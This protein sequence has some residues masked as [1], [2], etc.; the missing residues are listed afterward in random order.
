MTLEHNS[1]HENDENKKSSGYEEETKLGKIQN[2]LEDAFYSELGMKTFRFVMAWLA[3]GILGIF[4]LMMPLYVLDNFVPSIPMD[5]KENEYFIIDIVASYA[6]T[7]L[8]VTIFSGSNSWIVK[9][10][11]QI[12]KLNKRMSKVE[13][14]LEVDQTLKKA[15]D[16]ENLLMYAKIFNSTI[17][18]EDPEA[19]EIMMNDIK[20]SKTEHEIS[21]KKVGIDAKQEMTKMSKEIKEIKKKIGLSSY[22]DKLEDE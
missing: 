1:W 14:T 20:N 17:K 4:V 16:M 18:R 5:I 19:Y 6:F 13:D 12:P 8:H 9:N 10:L 3:F 7:I 2:V 11:N 15:Y 21:I 22:F